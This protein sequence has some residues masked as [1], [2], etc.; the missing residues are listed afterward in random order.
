MSGLL[1]ATITIG[2]VPMI[3][4]SM[5]PAAIASSSGAAYWKTVHS[6]LYPR[7]SRSCFSFTTAA[8]SGAGWI[9]SRIVFGAWAGACPDGRTAASAN[10]PAVSNASL[11]MRG[12]SG[13]DDDPDVGD[14][15]AVARVHVLR[16]RGHGD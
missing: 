5:E 1:T 10:K 12:T 13:V 7:F 15:E 16:A 14:G 11:R 9:P 8:S 3:P 4:M 2:S 6:G